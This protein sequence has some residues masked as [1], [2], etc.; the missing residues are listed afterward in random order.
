MSRGTARGH[1]RGTTLSHIRAKRGGAWRAARGAALRAGG[2]AAGGAAGVVVVQ[3]GLR[4]DAEPQAPG[5]AASRGL[6]GCWACLVCCEAATSLCA[7]PPVIRLRLEGGRGIPAQ[8]G[9]A[10]GEQPRNCGAFQSS[11]REDECD[12]CALHRAAVAALW[13]PDGAAHEWVHRATGERRRAAVD[14][15]AAQAAAG[16]VFF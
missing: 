6:L 9:D 7:I 2:V 8:L 1:A 12:F 15:G 10:G 11:G 3:A 13:R 4:P 14:E 16:S 5:A